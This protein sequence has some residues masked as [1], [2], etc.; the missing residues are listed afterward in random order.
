VRKRQTHTQNKQQKENKKG[1]NQ[2]KGL[3]DEDDNQIII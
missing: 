2:K 1:D 3:D